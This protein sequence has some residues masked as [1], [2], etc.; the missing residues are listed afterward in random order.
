MS[1][2]TIEG[3]W[4]I[5]KAGGEIDLSNIDEFR[6]AIDAAIAQSPHGC[7]IDLRDIAYIDSA[8]VAVVI[9]AY[10]RISKTGGTMAVVKPTSDGVRRVLD[11]IGLHLLPDI[12][13]AEN[14]DAA[15]EGL[16]ERTAKSSI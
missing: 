9:S 2:E 8:G 15:N 3:K 14:L 4:P 6:S 5:V 10:R 16:S 7:I 13:V 12:V 11:L 1:V